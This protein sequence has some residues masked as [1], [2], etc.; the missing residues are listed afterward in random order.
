MAHTET[1]V[2]DPK[3]LPLKFPRK[4]CFDALNKD[5]TEQ[6]EFEPLRSSFTRV[7]G[8]RS[9]TRNQVR[10]T[11]VNPERL[12]KGNGASIASSSL[13]SW[14]TC[15]P[16]GQTSATPMRQAAQT[17]ANGVPPTPREQQTNPLMQRHTSSQTSAHDERPTP[18]TTPKSMP[19]LH[20][21]KTGFGGI[22]MF[23]LCYNP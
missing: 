15:T 12:G 6:S 19:K 2:T 1:H 8:T 10:G 3:L 17:P 11:R 21:Q 5:T 22:S 20:G 13:P 23:V 9:P 7:R 18:L 16:S 14:S 4:N